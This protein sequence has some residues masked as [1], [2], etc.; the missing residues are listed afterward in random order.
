MLDADTLKF[1]TLELHEARSLPGEPDRVHQL[2]VTGPFGD[3]KW[4]RISPAEY[5]RVVEALTT[6]PGITYAV[7]PH[8]ITTLTAPMWEACGIECPAMIGAP[9]PGNTDGHYMDGPADAAHHAKRCPGKSSK[10]PHAAAEVVYGWSLHWQPE[11]C[12]DVDQP[13]GCNSIFRTP[14]DEHHDDNPM[15]AGVIL[16]TDSQGAVTLARYYDVALMEAEWAALQQRE[17]D[18]FRANCED[19]TPDAPCTDHADECADFCGLHV[20]HNGPCA[21]N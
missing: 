15:G 1:R 5:A 21:P 18:Y 3:S 13:I 16:N 6:E 14:E 4:L 12:G 11:T 2:K 9:C 10:F 17:A 19:C 20:D 7:Q 8:A